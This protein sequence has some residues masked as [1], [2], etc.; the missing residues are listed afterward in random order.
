VLSV[1]GVSI[2][3][4]SAAGTETGSGAGADADDVEDNGTVTAAKASG[5]RQR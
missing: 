2:A 1:K 4:G 3:H 5:L